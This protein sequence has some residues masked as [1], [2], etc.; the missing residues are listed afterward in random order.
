[1]IYVMSDIHGFYNRYK[2]IMRQIKLKKDDHLYVLGDCI[3][4]FPDGLAILY[5]SATMNT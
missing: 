2:S 5:F 4:R 3:D 1:M